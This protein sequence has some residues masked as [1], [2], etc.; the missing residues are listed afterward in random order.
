MSHRLVVRGL[1]VVSFGSA[2]WGAGCGDEEA[3]DNS[4]FGDAGEPFYDATVTDTDGASV[5]DGGHGGVELPASVDTLA[6]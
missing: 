4:L 6:S 1:L 3:A 5:S 2:L